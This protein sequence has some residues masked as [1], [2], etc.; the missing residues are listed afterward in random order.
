MKKRLAEDELANRSAVLEPNLGPAAVGDET[1]LLDVPDGA[2]LTEDDFDG[3][4]Q[5]PELEEDLPQ[6]LEEVFEGEADQTRLISRD[7]QPTDS[8][9]QM[10]A[11]FV[12]EGLDRTLAFQN[13]RKQSGTDAGAN[14]QADLPGPD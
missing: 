12:T 10:T 9:V 6:P 7:Q 13:E 8:D 1:T 2:P 14:R 11:D 3:L 5:L 4:D